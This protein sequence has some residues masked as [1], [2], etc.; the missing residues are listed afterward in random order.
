MC[1]DIYTYITFMCSSTGAARATR[2]CARYA[3]EPTFNSQVG[4][5]KAV[6][7]GRHALRARSLSLRYRPGD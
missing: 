5:R 2:P 4:T 1:T 6:T 7:T 3:V